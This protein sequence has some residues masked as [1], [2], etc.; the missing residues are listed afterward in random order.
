MRF[1]AI[2]AFCLVAIFALVQSVPDRK[3]ETAQMTAVA[4]Q[5]AEVDP[6]VSDNTAAEGPKAP[7][8]LADT[9]PVAA[10]EPVAMEAVREPVPLPDPVPE[11][12]EETEKVADVTPGGDAITDVTDTPAPSAPAQTDKR[13]FSLRFDSDAALVGLVEREEVALYAFARDKVWRF[14]MVEGRQTFRSAQPPRQFHEMARDTVPHQV[15]RTLR[16]TVVLPSGPLKWGVT[17]PAPTAA[18]LARVIATNEGGDLVIDENGYL[19][20]DESS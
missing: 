2:L 9:G 16:R 18:V 6:S 4:Q 1:M 14:M 8:R 3:P 19:H 15:V 20:L 11:E 10:P 17:L 12:V 13:G 5:V 7:D